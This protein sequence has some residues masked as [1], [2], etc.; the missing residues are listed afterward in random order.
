MGSDEDFND[1]SGKK[2][3]MPGLRATSMVE[4]TLNDLN[5]DESEAD[6]PHSDLMCFLPNHKPPIMGYGIIYHI[7]FR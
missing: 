1:L 5:D 6:Y 3:H 2:I 7:F 4:V